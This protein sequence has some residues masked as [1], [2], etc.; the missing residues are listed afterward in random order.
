MYKAVHVKK[1]CHVK[2][3]VSFYSKTLPD[4]LPNNI[5]RVVYERLIKGI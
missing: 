3:Y 1:F 2:P 5:E 4:S